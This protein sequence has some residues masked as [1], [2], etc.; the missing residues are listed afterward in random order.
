MSLT[1]ML[2]TVPFF[3]YPNT[4]FKFFLY[5][6]ALSLGVYITSFDRADRHADRVRAKFQ[7]GLDTFDF[8]VGK[9]YLQ[10]SIN[11]IQRVV[12]ILYKYASASKFTRHKF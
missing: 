5:G 12:P 11:V 3:A 1:A 7:R 8:V 10:R 2:R 9:Y 4:E 6:F